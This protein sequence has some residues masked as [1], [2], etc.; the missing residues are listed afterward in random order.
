MK[1]HPALTFIAGILV[2]FA[3]MYA[4]MP[5]VEERMLRTLEEGSLAGRVSVLEHSV[6]DAKAGAAKPVAASKDEAAGGDLR[7]L[8][9]IEK[10]LEELEWQIGRAHER[11]YDARLVSEAETPGTAYSCGGRD[12]KESPY[13]MVGRRDGCGTSQSLNYYRRL[14]LLIPPA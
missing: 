14:A 2:A 6:R 12:S 4:A 7:R 13:V 8:G 5:F 11:L 3:M 1:D 9:T 10:K